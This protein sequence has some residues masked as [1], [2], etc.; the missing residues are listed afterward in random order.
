[1][2]PVW[3]CFHDSNVPWGEGEVPAAYVAVEKR[4]KLMTDARAEEDRMN[5]DFRNSALLIRKFDELNTKQMEHADEGDEEEERKEQPRG[6]A[7]TQ[8]RKLLGRGKKL[9]TSDMFD[10]YKAKPNSVAAMSPARVRRSG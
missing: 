2:R 9:K 5:T 3:P 10:D 4:R 6:L 8:K 1:M 7:Q